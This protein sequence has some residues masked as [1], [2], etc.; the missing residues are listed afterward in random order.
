[1]IRPRNA[2]RTALAGL[3]AALSPL[4]A[5][6]LNGENGNGNGH[7]GSRTTARSPLGLE[8]QPFN[9]NPSTGTLTSLDIPRGL[10]LYSQVRNLD[11]VVRQPLLKS[12]TSQLIV[13]GIAVGGAVLAADKDNRK[14]GIGI[15]IPI[16]GI[17][18]HDLYSR[19]R[20]NSLQERVNTANA[21]IADHTS[22]IRVRNDKIVELREDATVDYE[23]KRDVY[24]TVQAL[25]A[26][27][28]KR[29]FTV[30][31]KN[32]ED[33]GKRDRLQTKLHKLK[34]RGPKMYV[35]DMLTEL[36]R[37]EPE[38]RALIGKYPLPKKK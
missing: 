38:A 1:M 16:T 14:Y 36:E 5:I 10:G 35:E 26:A 20:N 2:F 15:L 32:E 19:L 22:P 30:M 12:A 17:F 18:A 23:L 25:Y 21:L 24:E 9:Y 34:I 13:T 37:I 4:E 28:E 3:I 29:T 8:I 33:G 11:L 6:A 27:L 7:N 31:D